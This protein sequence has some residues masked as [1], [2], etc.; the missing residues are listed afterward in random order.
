MTAASVYP[1]SLA[2][3]KISQEHPLA[4]FLT[5]HGV[6]REEIAWFERH[7]ARPDILG[8]NYYSDIAKFE[9]EGDFTRKGSVPLDQAASEAAILVK[10]ALA[11]AQAYF[12]L[13]VYLMETSAG[14]STD[15]KIAYI[16]ALYQMILAF[17]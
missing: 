16:N 14:L 6:T 11:N 15:A 4:S 9:R 12:S 10:A 1:S 13:P 5:D 8:T 2:Y 7:S 3:G 17:S